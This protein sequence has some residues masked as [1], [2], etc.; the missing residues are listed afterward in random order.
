MTSD[1]GNT[2]TLTGKDFLEQQASLELS[3]G[4]IG[5][6]EGIELVVST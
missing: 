4:L 3:L 1:I 2:M 6:S 5:G